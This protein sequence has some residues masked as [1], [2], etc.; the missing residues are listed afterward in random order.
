M[1][2]G[3]ATAIGLDKGDGDEGDAMLIREATCC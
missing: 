1:F 3:A 2:G